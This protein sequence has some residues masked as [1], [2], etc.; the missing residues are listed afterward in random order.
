MPGS[1]G[2]IL[3]IVAYLSLINGIFR[4]PKGAK[5]FPSAMQE[6]INK[7]QWRRLSSVYMDIIID[8]HNK[9]YYYRYYIIHYML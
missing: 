9:Y 8:M 5:G 1:L 6:A 3:Y 4:V 2:T 7:R